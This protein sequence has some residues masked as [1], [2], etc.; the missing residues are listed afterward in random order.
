MESWNKKKFEEIKLYANFTK[1]NISISKK[2]TIRGLHFQNKPHGQLKFVQVLY[3]KVLDVVVDIR[4]ESKTF[5]ETFTIELSDSNNY[6]LWIPPG[7]AHGFLS[8]FDKSIFSYKCTGEYRPNNE[9]TI[10]WN[11]KDLNINWG[12]KKPIISKKDKKGIS[13]KKYIESKEIY[14]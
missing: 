7:C 4:K 9:H 2:N 12:V 10:I 5:G 6:G 14:G 8:L 1:S 11:D 13:F 3:G